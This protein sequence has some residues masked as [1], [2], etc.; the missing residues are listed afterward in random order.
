MSRVTGVGRSGGRPWAAAPA[1]NTTS[2]AERSLV[3]LRIADRAPSR[4]T[5]RRPTSR[6]ASW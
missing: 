3:L 2:A 4:P 1:W 5:G 6:R